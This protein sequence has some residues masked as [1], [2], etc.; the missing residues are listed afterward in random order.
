MTSDFKAKSI[1]LELVQ[2]HQTNSQVQNVQNLQKLIET[3]TG[4]ITVIKGLGSKCSA[5]AELLPASNCSNNKVMGVVRLSQLEDDTCFVDG[6]IGGFCVT[7]LDNFKHS[8]SIHEFGNLEGDSYDNIGD[9]LIV[10]EANRE[11]TQDG[12]LSIQKKLSKCD[13]STIIGRSIAVKQCDKICPAN[14]K[15]VISAGVIAR[16][17]IVEANKKQICSCSGKTLW[18]ERLE[19]SRDEL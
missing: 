10:I 13:V 9:E 16:A 18:E 4:F 14:P 5:V 8:L 19:K 15:K 11:V 1:Q 12:K 3:Q 7:T 2:N 17:S 6:L